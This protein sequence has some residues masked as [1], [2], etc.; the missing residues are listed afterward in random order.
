[1]ACVLLRYTERA[2]NVSAA[3]KLPI[4]LPP[5]SVSLQLFWSTF[6][7][8]LLSYDAAGGWQTVSTVQAAHR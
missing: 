4:P 5:L 3:S 7:L 1:M 8:S 6:Y 2:L